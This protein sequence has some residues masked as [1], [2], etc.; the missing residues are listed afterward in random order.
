MVAARA[1]AQRMQ[2][3]ACSWLKWRFVTTGW[4]VNL[5]NLG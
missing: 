5:V 2:A 1:L 4:A 3:D